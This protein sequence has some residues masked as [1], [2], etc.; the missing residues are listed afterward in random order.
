MPRIPTDSGP[1]VARSAERAAAWLTSHIDAY[2]C[3]GGNR[4]PGL[5]YKVPA[6][7]ALNG[8]R[9]TA[10]LVLDWIAAHLLA[11]DGTLKL[12][13]EVD[14]SRPVNTYDRGWLAWGAALCERHDLQQALADDLTAYQDRRT[15][16]FW[17]S[18]AGARLGRGT[19]GSDDRR[20]G[21]GWGCSPPGAHRSQRAEAARFLEELWEGQADPAAGFDSNRQLTADW[22]GRGGGAPPFFRE[23]SSRHYVDLSGSAQRPARFGPAMALL[24]RL[25]RLTG[26]PAHL[27]CARRYA[28][29]FL[30]R[31]ELYLCVECHKF[32]W[33]LAELQQVAPTTGY[34]DAAGKCAEYLVAAQ[35]PD[36]QL[37]SGGFGGG[38]GTELRADSQYP[39]QRACRPCL[40]P[41]RTGA[42]S[43]PLKACGS[44]ID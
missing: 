28:D 19:A 4:A 8:R 26:D 1:A 21:G 44:T 24:V 9:G 32:L 7:L 3:I 33:G 36:G 41:H 13:G 14:R 39:G 18:A 43:A 17:D 16:G 37:A 31:D 22:D 30:A 11:A 42:R 20:H 25:H 34:R 5:Y 2:G 6:A 12:P 38:R 15:G 35:H 10:A 40:L 23:R 27:A 29:L